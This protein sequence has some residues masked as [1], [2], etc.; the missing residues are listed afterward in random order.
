LRPVGDHLLGVTPYD[1]VVL[2]PRMV[3]SPEAAHP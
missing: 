1:G 3:I 2:E